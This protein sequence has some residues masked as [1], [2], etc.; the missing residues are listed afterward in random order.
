[1]WSQCVIVEVYALHALMTAIFLSV[2]YL[3]IRKP[4]SDGLMIATFFVLALSFSNHHLT[5]PLSFIPFLVIILLRREIFW[6]TILAAS[7][8]VLLAYLGFA[9]LS[10][11]PLV[12]R[13]AIRFFYCVALGMGVLI[14]IRRGAIRWNLVAFL[15]V[16]VAAGLLPYAY[17]PL[18]SS[19]N[20][21]MNWGYA[22]DPDGF[23]YSFNRSQY[24]GSLSTL[25]LKTLGA[26]MGTVPL[27]AELE[28]PEPGGVPGFRQPTKWQNIQWWTGFFW[29]QLAKAFTPFVMIGYFASIFAV[30][31]LSLP[32]RVWVYL[33]HLSFVL[34]AFLQALLEGVEIDASGWWLQMPYHT[35]TNLIFATLSAFGFGF[36]FTRLLSRAP[37]AAAALPLLL[38]LPLW[39][40]RDSEPSSSQ[41]DRW[42]GWKF[43][44]DML[45]DLPRGSVVYGGTDPGRF[46]PTYMIFGESFEDP[47]FKRDPSFDR[48]DLYIITQNALADKFYQRYIR[49]H[50][51]P[52]RPSVKGPFER[53]LGREGTYP[54]QRLILPTPEESEHILQVAAAKDPVTGAPPDEN[55]SIGFHSAVAKW[56]FERNRDKH[57]FF[58]EESFPMMWSYDYAVPHGLVYRLNK[59][60]LTAIPPEEVAKDFKFWEDYIK[61]LTS[62]PNFARDYDAQRSF[63]KLRL[64]MG[65]I[66]RYRKMGAEAERAY[67]QALALWAGNLDAIVA[68][69]P[70]LWDRG[71]FDG[72]IR[73]LDRAAQDDPNNISTIRLSIMAQKRKELE[74][75]IG[76][77]RAEAEQN[78]HSA[79]PA[80]RLLNLYAQT[81]DT[82]QSLPLIRSS[83][84]NLPGDPDFQRVALGYL[85]SVGMLKDPVSVEMADR[86]VKTEPTS[87]K[88]FYLQSRVLYAKGDK[89][90]FKAAAAKAV[91]LGGLRLR[92]VYLADPLFKDE[93][94]KPDFLQ[95]LTPQ[96]LQ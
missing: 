26:A 89:D 18:A 62:D 20:P 40:M 82:N 4:E 63:S 14:W 72:M 65:N 66:Y 60:K 52:D 16:A 61:E 74:G 75:E 15:P 24:S 25:S 27:G 2:L 78:P 96:I 32:K 34:A 12:L 51:G 38:L 67:R 88:N 35:Y 10:K 85:D 94:E 30:L 11:D 42:F 44:H 54:E 77:A 91:Q 79:D 57:D 45:K 39:T 13:T 33:L 70:M 46:V 69:N 58:V 37:R 55:P 73:L 29:V 3:W 21:P 92:E 68:L 49:D 19:T 87:A 64:T 86:L 9:I 95:M 80:K 50:Y 93:R 83:M 56:I 23:Y 36:L 71:D 47:K 8:V 90:A 48:R 41:K 31:R 53:W 76:A 6:D 7:L 5:L 17:T 81:G 43:G 22:R 1:M 28:R 59:E 84:T